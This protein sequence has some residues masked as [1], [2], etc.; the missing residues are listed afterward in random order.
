MTIGII[1]TQATWDAAVK[2]LPHAP[3]TQS[4]DWGVFHMSQGRTVWRVAVQEKKQDVDTIIALAQVA[5][6]DLP[7]GYVYLQCSFGPHVIDTALQQ[8]ALLLLQQFL[9]QL[10][11]T[12]RLLFMRA[13]PNVMPGPTW[14]KVRDRQP[15]HTLVV[16]L[17]KSEEELLAA[18]HPKTRYNISLAER[19]GV[20]VRFGREDTD[21]DAFISCIRATYDRKNINAFPESYYRTQVS[22]IPWEYVAIAEFEGKPIVANLITHFGD[23][24]TYVHGGSLTEFKALMAPHLLQW[25]CMQEAKQRGSAYYDFYGIAPDNMPDHPWA[26]ITR[27]KTGFG[28]TQLTRPGTFELPL[29]PFLY[30]LVHTIQRFRG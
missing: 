16:D 26:G 27:F 22:T 12:E 2:S 19:K 29:H 25:R 17:K 13:E 20:T 11:R 15:T 10:S 3:F 23:T 14:K 21:M 5:K 24:T 8:E 4:W 9:R 28:G 30:T 18:M 6:I 1:K 7:L